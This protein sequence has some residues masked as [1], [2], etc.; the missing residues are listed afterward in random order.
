MNMQLLA[1]PKLSETTEGYSA[2]PAAIDG[3]AIKK[4]HAEQLLYMKGEEE[5]TVV[6]MMFGKAV[7][8]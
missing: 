4:Q 3:M 6:E 1:T 8:P 2:Q 5:G 7:N